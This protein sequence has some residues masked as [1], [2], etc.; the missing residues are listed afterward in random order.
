MR[1][2]QVQTGLRPDRNY[3]PGIPARVALLAAKR[4]FFHTC[5]EQL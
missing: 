4:S 1:V 2:A 5:G 3:A